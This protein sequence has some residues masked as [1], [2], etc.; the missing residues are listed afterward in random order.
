MR[1]R[2]TVLTGAPPRT[3]PH[4]QQRGDVVARGGHPGAQPQ[5][6]VRARAPRSGAVLLGPVLEARRS[7]SGAARRRSPGAPSPATSAVRAPAV[8][9]AVELVLPRRAARRPTSAAEALRGGGQRRRARPSATRR[10]P[11]NVA[12]GRRTAWY[13]D[14]ALTTRPRRLW[15]RKRRAAGACRRP[16]CPCSTRGSAI[17]PASASRWVDDVAVADEQRRRRRGGER[18]DHA[19]VGGRR[20]GAPRTSMPG[21]RPPSD[22]ASA[23]SGRVRTID[24][25]DA[26][27]RRAGR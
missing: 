21:A 16:A 5:L 13:G 8:G 22:F 9:L 24:R 12:F 23:H 3:R 27:R 11:R 19:Q 26:E 15:T 7:S 10:T 18:R 25:A 6:V 4:Q 17:R 2:Y 20:V 14:A 1:R